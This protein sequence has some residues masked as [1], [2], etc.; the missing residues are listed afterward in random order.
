MKVLFVCTRN[1]ARSRMAESL[2][3][4]MLHQ[5][6]HHEARSVGMASDASRR[7]TTRDL[8]WADVVA[9]MEEPHRTLIEANWPNH[10]HKVVVLGVVD[11]YDPEEPE[12]R[13]VLAP[14]IRALIER[15]E[16]DLAS[17]APR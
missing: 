14:K 5:Q 6:G 10:G 1:V 8:V 16:V 7:L 13:G 11:E 3:G 2:L 12:L 9:V 4:E 15:L 17:G